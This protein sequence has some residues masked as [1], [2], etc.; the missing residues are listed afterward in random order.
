M[1]SAPHAEA[2]ACAPNLINLE[3]PA[4]PRRGRLYWL[5]LAL[6]AAAHGALLAYLIAFISPSA[7]PAGQERLHEIRVEV[8]PVRRDG[9]LQKA[10]RETGSSYSRMGEIN[11]LK[12]RLMPDTL[13]VNS[14]LETRGQN[15]PED[16]GVSVRERPSEAAGTTDPDAA[17]P[18]DKA[19]PFPAAVDEPALLA[20]EGDWPEDKAMPDIAIQPSPEQAVLPPPGKVMPQA[21]VPSPEP[22]EAPGEVLS[23]AAPSDTEKADATPTAANPLEAPREVRSAATPSDPVEAEAALS[24]EPVDAP[25]AVPSDAPPD[26]PSMEDSVA[27]TPAAAADIAGEPGGAPSA[28]LPG[29]RV[30]Y[31][32]EARAI[33]PRAPAPL[34]ISMRAGRLP[35]PLTAQCGR[36]KTPSELIWPRANRP[37]AMAPGASSS[38]LPYRAQARSSR[39]KS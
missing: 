9:A 36:I 14:L 35:S 10:D 18:E 13:P 15:F 25:E 20:A 28:P 12:P 4:R 11:Q 7:E 37:D 21:K 29:R 39:R 38:V 5:S 24:I 3:N 27:S 22:F 32:E 8:A 30:A 23:A 16:S 1:Y 6:A 17:L 33:S 31:N 2:P 34:T 19:L 26:A